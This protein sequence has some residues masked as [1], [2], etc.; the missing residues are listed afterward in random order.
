MR[1]GLIARGDNRGLGIQ[2]WEWARG[3]EPEQ[4]LLVDQ[5]PR[6]FPFH[7]E[8]YPGAL[9]VAC[10][11]HQLP[12]QK[13]REWL[14]GV[15]V[16]YTA[17]T[18]YDP[19]LPRWAREQGVATVCHLNP[20]FFR[21]P[22]EQPTAWWAPSSWRLELLPPGTR[23]VPV[24]VPIDR[25]PGAWQAEPGSP[26]CWVHVAGSRTVADRNGSVIVGKAA[27]LLQ[28]Q[29]RLILRTQNAPLPLLRPR[30]NV[31][32]V[33]ARAV[34]QY[35]EL[36]AGADAL[37]LPRRFGGLCLPVLEAAAA[38]LG[39]LMSGSSPQLSDYPVSTVRVRPGRQLSTAAGTLQLEDA[40]P[41]ALAAQMDAWARKPGEL[42]EAR[43][44]A[45]AWGAEHSWP[46]L[47]PQIR[48]ELERAVELR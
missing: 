14:A 47:A 38:G 6:A 46:Q 48:C 15:D 30:P 2:T 31:E 7:P 39:I 10:R 20:E 18:F 26:P 27:Q 1:V 41:A 13:V 5:Q 40:D 11:D 45:R 33:K 29:H 25:F 44:R 12:E 22:E 37:V 3:M 28:E 17:E 24:P 16:L 42:A 23:Q 34:G 36:Y 32:V 4:V 9:T 35:W 19:Q 43:L 8:R 21:L